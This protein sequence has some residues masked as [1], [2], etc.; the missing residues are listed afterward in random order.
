MGARGGDGCHRYMQVKRVQGRMP[1]SPPGP[2]TIPAVL[3]RAGSTP[4]STVPEE[5]R[6]APPNHPEAPGESRFEAG[7]GKDP[8]V[9]CGL[10]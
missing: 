9:G 10:G 5:H 8:K 4:A 3:A 6:H 7:K 1:R 2:G